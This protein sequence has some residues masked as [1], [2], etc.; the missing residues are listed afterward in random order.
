MIVLAWNRLGAVMRVSTLSSIN[1]ANDAL[2]MHGALAIGMEARRADIRYEA[3][4]EARQLGPRGSTSSTAQTRNKVRMYLGDGVGRGPPNTM[5]VAA[6]NVSA[7]ADWS[8]WG[9]AV[10][11]ADCAP[12][13]D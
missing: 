2:E 11:V 12:A 5:R 8:G 1:A 13:G 10:A 4:C 3:R 7:A 9:P 6:V